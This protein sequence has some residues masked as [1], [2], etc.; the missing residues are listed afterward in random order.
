MDSILSSLRYCSTNRVALASRAV[1]LSP[2]FALVGWLCAVHPSLIRL[3]QLCLVSTCPVAKLDC[4]QT[5]AA[6][7]EPLEPDIPSSGPLTD[8]SGLRLQGLSQAS[9]ETDKSGEPCFRSGQMVW[10]LIS[11]YTQ[12]I[13]PSQMCFEDNVVCGLRLRRC[14]LE[15]IIR[16]LGCHA[17]TQ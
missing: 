4:Q 7:L 2:G 12:I 14:P 1:Q 11:R 16:R 8:R 15:P 17:L 6:L 3:R 9:A 5:C 10:P 13:S